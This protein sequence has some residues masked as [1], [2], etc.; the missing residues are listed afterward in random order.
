MPK[1]II[2]IDDK[3]KGKRNGNMA[4]HNIFSHVA[5]PIIP[6]KTAFALQNSQ[7]NSSPLLS[8]RNFERTGTRLIPFNFNN[9][10]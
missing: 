5:F 2:I 9:K 8:A 6:N 4:S 1:I 10:I 3:T 7:S